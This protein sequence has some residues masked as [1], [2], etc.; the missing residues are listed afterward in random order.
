M[1]KVIL[2]DI[3]GVLIRLPKYFSSVLEGNGYKDAANILDEYYT[4]GNNNS[5]LIGKSDPLISIKPYLDRIGWEF[6]PNEYFKQ[7]YEYESGYAD[8]FLLQKITAM[9]SN[10]LVCMTAT[11]QDALRSKFLLDNLN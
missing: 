10:G 1:Y 5:C 4:G 8:H 6:T 9:R 2:F 3:D 11:D 7:Q